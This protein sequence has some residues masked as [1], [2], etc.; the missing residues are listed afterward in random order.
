MRVVPKKADSQGKK[1]WRMVID[2]RS[3]NEKTIGDA[4]P[5]PNITDILDP[6]GGARYFTVL[7]PAFGFYQI[8]VEPVD[9]HK[10]AFSTFLV[11]LSL[12][13]CPLVLRTFPLLSK[14]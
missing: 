6:L 2:Y 7:D 8:D 4:F 9:R 1:R 10:T 12:T 5:L 13:E 11:I 3:L 14:G